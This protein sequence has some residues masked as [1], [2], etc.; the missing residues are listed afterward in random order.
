MNFDAVIYEKARVKLQEAE[1]RRTEAREKLFSQDELPG[2]ADGEW[3][4]F[5]V[6]GDGS[7]PSLVDS[8]GLG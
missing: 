3:Q 6:A 4:E 1:G 8:R 7:A 2:P 5:I